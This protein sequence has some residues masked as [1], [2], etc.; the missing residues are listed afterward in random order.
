MSNLKLDNI[1]KYIDK[2]RGNLYG[3]IKNN[4]MIGITQKIQFRNISQDGI[5]LIGYLCKV[6]LNHTFKVWTFSQEQEAISVYDALLDYYGNTLKVS[7][8]TKREEMREGEAY[9]Y[10]I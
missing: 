6:D 8:H 7:A 9:I 5:P 10:L 1:K 4:G 3:G 2:E